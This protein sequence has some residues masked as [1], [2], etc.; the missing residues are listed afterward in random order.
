MGL[1][2][3][4]PIQGRVKACLDL[5][6]SVN[7][8]GKVIVDVGSSVGWVERALIKFGARE[9]TGIEPQKQVLEFAERNVKG[10]KFILGDALNIPI[11]DKYADLVLLFDVLEHVP[12]GTEK[13]ALKEINRILKKNGLLLLSTPHDNFFIKV[14]DPAWYF[15]HRHYSKSQVKELIESSGFELVNMTLKGNILS[16]LYAIWF[17]IMKYLTGNSQPQ[18]K[19]FESWEEKGYKEGEMGTIFLVAKVKK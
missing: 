2:L 16:S 18:S 7:P 15:G 13:K 8:K 5:V 1:S 10:A 12:K 14:L 3:N 9:V 19:F 11:K 6:K 17:Y 4:V